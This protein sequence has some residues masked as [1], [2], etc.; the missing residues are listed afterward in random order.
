MIIL[1]AG[2]LKYIIWINYTD[3]HVFKFFFLLIMMF[4]YLYL[5]KI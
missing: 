2:Y 4:S 5:V 3:D 1:Q